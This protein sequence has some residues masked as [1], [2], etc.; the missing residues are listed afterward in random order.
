MDKVAAK[1][2][3]EAMAPTLAPRVA[4]QAS[5]AM[6]AAHARKVVISGPTTDPMAAAVA[7]VA[8][9]SPDRTHFAMRACVR[10]TDHPFEMNPADRR[11]HPAS[12]TPSAPASTPSP[13]VVAIAATATAMEMVAVDADRVLPPVAAVEARQTRCAPALVESSELIDLV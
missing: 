8:K 5:P 7:R 9:A 4:M 2:A 6:R 11:V 12:P 10:T 1:A 13:T 3:T